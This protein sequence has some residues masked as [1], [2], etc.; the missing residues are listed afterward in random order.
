M[1]YIC[2]HRRLT[3]DSVFYVG[4]GTSH[5]AWTTNGRS[6]FWSKTVSKYGLKVEIV[7]YD[8]SEEDAFLNEKL[9]IKW[10]GRRNNFT[11]CLV[12]L[13]DGGEGASGL[14]QSDFCRK[15]SSERMNGLNN[16]KADTNIYRFIN[17]HTHQIEDCTR[18]EL[19][20]KYSV[21]ISDLFNSKVRS[22][23]GW[24][25]LDNQLSG[26]YDETIYTFI[27]KDGSEFIGTRAMFKKHFG[28]HVKPLFCKAT[29]HW[30]VKGWKL[31]E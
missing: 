30:A 28:F 19:E 16:P 24:R 27:H 12:N 25:L 8:L 9:F 23:N 18:Y 21:S 4:K 6:E 13:T 10:F 17:I 22:V 1:F 14:I 29:A 11:G 31:K 3:D 15:V 2:V 5:R 20:S 26:K 7:L